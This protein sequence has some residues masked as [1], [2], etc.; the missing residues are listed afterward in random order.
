ME[1][2]IKK[3]TAVNL[4]SVLV[5]TVLCV[6]SGF[7]YAQDVITFTDG[8]KVEAKV[9]EVDYNI[10]TRTAL[11]TQPEFTLY[12]AFSIRTEQLKNIPL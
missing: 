12:I 1:K 10:I 2:L 3:I 7:L 9:I 4:K 11:C 5:V 6:V 8:R